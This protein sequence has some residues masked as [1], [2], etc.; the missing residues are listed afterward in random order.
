MYLPMAALLWTMECGRERHAFKVALITMLSSCLF[1]G[2]EF[3]TARAVM[4]FM[5]VVFY[6]IARGWSKEKVVKALKKVM[7]Y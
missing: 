5:P 1:S 3:I 2:A 4:A 7:E 6:A